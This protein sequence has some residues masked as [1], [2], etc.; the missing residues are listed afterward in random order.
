MLKA[1]FLVVLMSMIVCSVGSAAD[2]WTLAYSDDFSR[3]ELGDS[4]KT[5]IG[6]ARIVD[7]SMEIKAP[8]VGM[9][10]LQ[11]SCPADVKV[12]YTAWVPKGVQRCDLT[13]ILGADSDGNRSGYF[14]G[15]GSWMDTK[16][17]ILKDDGVELDVTKQYLIGAN[18]QRHNMQAVKDGNHVY[19][20]V[21]GRRI[22]NATDDDPCGGL[23]EDRVAFYTWNSVMRVDNVRV[24]VKGKDSGQLR[25]S[26][27][28]LSV[29]QDANGKLRNT[30]QSPNPG[31]G[32]CLELYNAGKLGEAFDALAKRPDTF[33]KAS[34]LAWVLGNVDFFQDKKACR[35]MFSCIKSL[36][37]Q[38]VAPAK[39]GALKK[40]T[41]WLSVMA[42]ETKGAPTHCLPRLLSQVRPGHP[43]Y[44][45]ALLYKAR[46]VA[47]DAKERNDGKV[48]PELAAILKPLLE[49]H[50]GNRIIRIYL[51]ENIPWEQN[52]DLDP[53][54]PKWARDLCEVY[55]RSLA[56]IE[57]WGK[58]RQ[59]SEGGVGGGWG[60]DCELLRTWAP[61]A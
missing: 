43:F 7:G 58:N 49:K 41:T 61:I 3:S 32:R 5:V 26:D 8:G 13:T 14:L 54:A 30:D 23:G 34:A 19:L 52:V 15:Y 24:Y 25:E 21:D 27:L 17:H 33:Q 16:N 36:S 37:D 4:W 57:W 35:S 59:D 55:L 20:V 1:V 48:P 18:E 47:W 60:D 31:I 53:G 40:L 10:L 29:V 42:G 50:P 46:V 51:G 38:K 44:E 28:Q 56:V 11:V 9:C 2:D 12:E 22:L 39:V 45:K 6:E